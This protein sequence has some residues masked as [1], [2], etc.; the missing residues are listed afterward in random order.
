MSGY[1]TADFVASLPWVGGAALL[2][3]V[4][5]FAVAKVAGKHSVIDSAW[6]MLFVA[7]AVV[8]F[9]R[10][11]GSG[12]PV[13]R[14]LLLALT[15]AWG[16][17]LAVHI[18]RRTVGKPEDPRYEQLLAKGGKHPHLYAL[19]VIYLLQGAITFVVA[20]PVLVG[21]F[22]RG[23][24][25]PVAWVGVVLWCV[26]VFFEAVG[27]LQMERFRADP[28]H[29][30]TVMDRGLWRYTRHPN[31]FGDA[32]VWW[33]I[34]LVAASGWPAVLTV[35]G[36]IVMTLLLTIGSGVRIMERQMSGRPGWDDYAERTS[37]FLPRPPKRLARHRPAR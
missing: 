28:A 27:D 37:V 34:F 2:V 14:W 32:C 9:V 18:G 19:L 7:M 33:G 12:D 22:V 35:I 23:G 16:L 25:S 4:V 15:A 26:G 3:L 24:V 29:R 6:G 31:Y 11:D 30:G 13:R 36:P 17:R 10:S 5:T 20:G 21:A 8:A 1:P